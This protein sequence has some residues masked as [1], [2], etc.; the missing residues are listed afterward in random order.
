MPTRQGTSACL[1]LLPRTHGPP[2]Y[3][4]IRLKDFK[5]CQIWSTEKFSIIN[6]SHLQPFTLQLTV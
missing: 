6:F 5:N 3:Q 4:V 1:P 2:P